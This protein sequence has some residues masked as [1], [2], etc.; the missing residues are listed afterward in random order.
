ML[1]R[2]GA[3]RHLARP[4]ARH[5]KPEGVNIAAGVDAPA[6]LLFR[7]RELGRLWHELIVP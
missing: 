3:L 5:R 1:P 6:K 2:G 7:C 4:G